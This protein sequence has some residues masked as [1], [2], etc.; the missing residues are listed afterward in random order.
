M[1]HKTIFF[2]INSKY[3]EVN[4]WGKFNSFAAI[5][6]TAKLINELL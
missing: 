3:Y 5:L 6:M 1:D 4:L 2:V